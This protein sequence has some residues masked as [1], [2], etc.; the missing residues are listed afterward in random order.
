LSF[1]EVQTNLQRKCDIS[2]DKF[3]Y[4]ASISY[5][6]SNKILILMKSA[7]HGYRA[8]L[9]DKNTIEVRD[10]PK[11]MSEG[12]QM[13]THIA[14]KVSDGAVYLLME[15]GNMLTCNDFVKYLNK[16]LYRYND[17]RNTEDE[18][19]KGLFHIDMIIRNDFHQALEKMHRVTCANMYI[20]K[21][22]LGDE[23]L[24]FSNRIEV[25]KDEIELKINAKRGQSV[26][27]TVYDFFHH[28]NGNNSVIRRIRVRG[29]SETNIGSVID[30]N[31]WGKKDTITVSQ[32]A[33]TGEYDSNE[34][35][36]RLLELA[37]Q[38]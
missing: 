35:F 22:V 7:R 9:I 26:K 11:T 27:N 25:I 12:E 33:D 38:I 14:V 20:E 34:M 2:E 17:S 37:N 18:K 16:I 31:F 5:N 19:L 13:K 36:S 10:N 24:N 29:E 32:N 3:A 1:W 30:T 28:F 8:P 23:M 6:E 4:M 21:R 15:S